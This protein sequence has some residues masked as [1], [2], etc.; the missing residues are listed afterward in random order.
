MFARCASHH[1]RNI[2]SETTT[3][4]PR[5][6]RGFEHT[7]TSYERATGFVVPIKA[8]SPAS[9]PPDFH[10]QGVV[11]IALVYPAK[12]PPDFQ[13]QGVFHISPTYPTP[14]LHE[15]GVVHITLVYPMTPSGAFRAF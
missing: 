10:K 5:A 11:P 9:A 4:F 2:L 15:Q 12:T 13:A 7:H 8:T 3:H 14:D 1:T 6:R